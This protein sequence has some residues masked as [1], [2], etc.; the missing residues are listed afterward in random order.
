[1]PCDFPLSFFEPRGANQGHQGL[2]RNKAQSGPCPITSRDIGCVHVQLLRP[3]LL[4]AAVNMTDSAATVSYLRSLQAVGE[5]SEQ[6]FR[7]LQAGKL[8][9]WDW[10]PEKLDGVVD[11]CIG[12]MEVCVVVWVRAMCLSLAGLWIRLELS[13]CLPFSCQGSLNFR[14]R[15]SARPSSQCIPLTPSTQPSSALPT[16]P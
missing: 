4:V 14:Y 16:P 6:V 8:D 15:V 1:M 2:C 3:F 9:H 10:Q 5:R 7:L 13:E 11:Y 12:L